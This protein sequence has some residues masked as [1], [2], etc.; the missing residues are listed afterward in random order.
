[1]N[2]EDNVKKVMALVDKMPEPRRT[3][4]KE[5]L[6]GR[7]GEIYFTAPASTREDFH[8]AFPGGLAAHSLN[9]VANL[10]RLSKALC[11]DR[12]PVGTLAFVGLFHD[13]G[14][15]GDGTD[16]FYV[17][18]ENPYGRNKGFLFEVNKKLPYMSTSER[19]MFIFQKLGIE[20]S[21]EE[22]LALKLADG[23]YV[24]ENRPYAMKEP[25]LAILVH[26]ADRWSCAEEKD[27][28]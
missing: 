23:Q 17:P 14:K 4:V 7:I 18:N 21:F 15:V 25:D 3:K 9:V 28:K 1:M 19:T 20:V 5:M 11:P 6:E 13:L 12:W 16:E 26:F 27:P 2:A 8:N 10:Y 22:Y 24:D